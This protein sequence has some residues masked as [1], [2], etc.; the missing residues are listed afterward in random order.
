MCQ[1]ASAVPILGAILF[2]LALDM[3]R[4]R[5]LIKALARSARA[6]TITRPEYCETRDRVRKVCMSW[7]KPLMGLAIVALYNTIGVLVVIV[8]NG[9]LIGSSIWNDILFCSI[10]AKEV[11]LLF[12]FLALATVVNDTAEDLTTDIYQWNIDHGSEAFPDV[13]S[14][15]RALLESNRRL[16]ILAEATNFLGPEDINAR[17]WIWRRASAYKAGGIHFTVL[18]I[19]W[20]STFVWTLGGTLAL[21]FFSA[22]ARKWVKRTAR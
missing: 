9:E 13:E 1:I 22:F 6:H 7:D 17:Y 16:E 20:S 5:K 19:R 21:S 3:A 4:C 8:N 12:T 10:L 2:A 15:V 11:T 18:G 14:T